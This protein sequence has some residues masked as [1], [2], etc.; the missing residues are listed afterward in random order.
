MILGLNCA[1]H[2]SAAALI[3]GEGR[4]V[5]AAEEERFTGRKHG[6]PVRSDNAHHLPAHAIRFCLRA[7]GVTWRDL[8]AV[9]YSL[10]PELR[11]AAP[12]TGPDTD[13][14]AFGH[15]AAEAAFLE[16]LNRVPRLIAQETSAPF[17]FVPHHAAHAWY[18]MA[19]SPY[20]RAAVFVADGIGECASVSAGIAT[21]YLLQLEQ[22]AAVPDSIGM[23]WEKVSRYVGLTEYDACKVMAL[24]GTAT[25]V[26]PL[27]PDRLFSF[28][29]GG[30]W[31]DQKNLILDFPNDYSG[32]DA[33]LGSRR[34]PHRPKPVTAPEHKRLAAGLQ[35]ATER[36]L[37][38]AAAQLVE[39]CG[40]RTLVYGGGV[41]LNCRANHVLAASG[42]VDHLHVG[43][44]THDAGTAL[45]AAWHAYTLTS[46]RPIPVQ[47]PSLILFSGPDVAG[48]AAA[49]HR[50]GWQKHPGIQD[51]LHTLVEALLQGHPIGW[52]D[53]RGEF[54]PRALGARSILASPLIPG[55][56]TRV[57]QLK[58]RHEF[59]PLA[60]SVPEEDAPSLFVVPEPARDLSQLMLTTSYPTPGARPKLQH[61][62]HRD[63]TTRLQIVKPSLTPRLHALLRAFGERSELPLLVNTSF[64]PRGDP[65]PA[66]LTQALP[67]VDRLGLSYLAING[68]LWMSP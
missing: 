40:E 30:L 38:A 26:R 42:V 34:D 7:G 44:A 2:E 31:V 9:A 55:A 68:R 28:R 46:R 51:D 24:A 65:M 67:M 13:P 4:I 62:L 32:L 33:L 10:H 50:A 60:L 56:V 53:G 58:G 45:G 12:F 54:G 61:V 43:P 27:S 19:T 18:A 14:G 49:L 1:Y 59:E 64:N 17:F 3:D 6:K 25:D 21:R 20:E 22:V 23:A 16:S 5:A 48:D 47:D 29:D 36:F 57:N 15:H 41:A 8:R 52:L 11:R 63:G 66:T 35:R 37:V 39:R